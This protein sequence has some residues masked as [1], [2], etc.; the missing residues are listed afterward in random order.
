MLCYTLSAMIKYGQVCSIVSKHKYFI[1]EKPRTSTFD[2]YN[3]TN[4]QNMIT[5]DSHPPFY[6]LKHT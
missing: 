2:D 5:K 4:I 6:S 1:K 3:K